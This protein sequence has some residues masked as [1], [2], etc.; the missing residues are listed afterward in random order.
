MQSQILSSVYTVSKPRV[1]VASKTK[2]QGSPGKVR[3]CSFMQSLGRQCRGEFLLWQDFS[4]STEREKKGHRPRS[5][6]RLSQRGLFQRSQC[7]FT[8]QFTLISTLQSCLCTRSFAPNPYHKSTTDWIQHQD[9]SKALF[10]MGNKSCSSFFS[11][12]ISLCAVRHRLIFPPQ[13]W[14]AFDV[15]QSTTHFTKNQA[16]NPSGHLKALTK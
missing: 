8:Y 10:Y 9:K 15:D 5:V 3:S 7:P 2:A 6:N 12:D 13:V 14:F 11:R 4:E 16:V 1:D